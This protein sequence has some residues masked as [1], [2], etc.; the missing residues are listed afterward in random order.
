MSEPRHQFLGIAS[1][2]ATS[3][4]AQIGQYGIGKVAVLRIWLQRGKHQ[5][6]KSLIQRDVEA[7]ARH[8]I[9][10]AYKADLRINHRRCRCSSA[11][12]VQPLARNAGHFPVTVAQ[13]R[14]RFND[15]H[16]L[17]PVHA[18]ALNCC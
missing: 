10:A 13:H 16:H 3:L 4:L 9:H 6:A 14:T 7:V 1:L 5:V 17:H 2:N 12:H 8:V 11:A 18:E 15:A